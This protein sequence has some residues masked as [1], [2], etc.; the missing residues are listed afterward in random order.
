MSRSRSP[1]PPAAGRSEPP[2]AAR[3]TRLLGALIALLAALF[4]A[5][6]APAAQPTGTS[7]SGVLLAY[8]PEAASSNPAEL[9]QATDQLAREL[10]A[11]LPGRGLEAKIYRRF[12]D[13]EAFLREH[14]SRVILLLVD[15]PFLL[16]LPAGFEVEPRFRFVRGGAEERHYQLLVRA[17]APWRSLADLAGRTLTVVPTA[18]ANT[19]LFLERVLFARQVDDPKRFFGRIDPAIDDPSALANVQFASTDA[20][21]VADDNPQLRALVGSTLRVLYTSPASSLPVLAMRRGALDEAARDA[22]ERLVSGLPSAPN[23]AAILAGLGIEAFRRVDPRQLLDRRSLLAMGEVA[24]PSFEIALPP[25]GW[26]PQAAAPPAAT[27]LGFFVE[28]ELPVIPLG[29]SAP[30]TGAQRT[31]TNPAPPPP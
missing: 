27:T 15:A 13:A 23:G 26:R 22:V 8:L 1:H 20:A 9:A 31:A 4:A 29:E 24:R 30:A 25:S 11:A 16:S 10:A 6:P 12:E 7:E 3:R 17:D 14:G 28:L 18:G 21:L 5:P 2:G 19:T